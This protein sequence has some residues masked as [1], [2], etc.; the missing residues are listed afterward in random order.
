M[1]HGPHGFRRG[2]SNHVARR[3][4][5]CIRDVLPNSPG[6]INSRSKD[7][8][9]LPLISLRGGML[10][11][12]TRT[13]SLFSRDFPED[14]PGMQPATRTSSLASGNLPDV[15]QQPALLRRVTPLTYIDRT[16]P[17]TVLIPEPNQLHLPRSVAQEDAER[18]RGTIAAATTP[19]IGPVEHP[20]RTVP[21]LAEYVD[22]RFGL[23]G[24]NDEPGDHNRFRSPAITFTAPDYG[25]DVD[26]Q[27]DGLSEDET[28]G[29]S[30]S[31]PINSRRIS[32]ALRN[33]ASRAREFFPT[34]DIVTSRRASEVPSTSR[35]SRFSVTLQRALGEQ[36]LIAR[37]ANMIAPRTSFEQPSAQGSIPT[38]DGASTTRED[39]FV[40]RTGQTRGP[41]G[42]QPIP[43]CDERSHEIDVADRRASD[44]LISQVTRDTLAQGYIHGRRSLPTTNERTH[45]D[46]R[47][48]N[49]DEEHSE[50]P[51][52]LQRAWYR[53]S[54]TLTSSSRFGSYDGACAP[55]PTREENDD[56]IEPDMAS[57]LRSSQPIAAR[58]GTRLRHIGT[59]TLK[60]AR[61]GASR[62]LNRPHVNAHDD[63]RSASPSR[64]CTSDPVDVTSEGPRTTDENAPKQ[65][66][67]GISLNSG[68]ARRR[69]LIPSDWRGSIGR[70]TARL[71]RHNIP[72][73][74][75][76][77]Q[78]TRDAISPAD[79]G[80][81]EGGAGDV[82]DW[83]S[84]EVPRGPRQTEGTTPIG[85]S[86]DVPRQVAEL[87]NEQ[88]QTSWTLKS[89]IKR[90]RELSRSEQ[91]VIPS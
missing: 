47:S 65:V 13:P 3:W 50:S 52:V 27:D 73:G 83:L 38:L 66:S 25:H 40:S 87:G 33:I 28:I 57:S 7:C 45:S 4:K 69:R 31:G 6:A 26:D 48:N 21:D 78:Q 19:I 85:R 2:I 9:L 15:D 88:R 80:I 22:E 5:I 89:M 17:G 79:C 35:R 8:S 37:A 53:L 67:R 10:D 34:T 49:R 54:T 71:K 43:S 55:P 29:E 75:G 61:W 81:V 56:H 20:Q 42:P 86:V 59:S 90:S 60:L 64:D 91:N 30:A 74:H 16:E 72:S 62:L 58:F 77:A 36:N 14:T 39:D 23:D 46:A 63:Q 51:S 18:A 12:E 44:P 11:G 84:Q 41:M 70:A 76:P 32:D 82:A 24:T 68:R 1:V